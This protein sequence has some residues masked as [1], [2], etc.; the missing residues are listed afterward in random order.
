MFFALSEQL[1]LVKGIDM[2]HSQIRQTVVNYL[3]DSPTQ[4]RKVLVV[5]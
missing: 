4:V 5:T 1:N 3:R 2:S